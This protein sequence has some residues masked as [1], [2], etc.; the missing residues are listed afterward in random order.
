MQQLALALSLLFGGTLLASPRSGGVALAAV[1]SLAGAA[2]TVAFGETIRRGYGWSRRLAIALGVALTAG[3][4]ASIPGTVDDL[5]HG[6]VWSSVP[7]V[8]LLTA[9][10]L[11]AVGFHSA[12]SRAWFAAVTSAEAR[13]RHGGAWLVTL[14][15]IAIVSGLFVAYAEARQR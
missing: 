3:G 8:V 7:I 14:A 2:V 1:G 15:A 4:L 9:G 10:P 12:R 5:R 11:I 13:R 6:F